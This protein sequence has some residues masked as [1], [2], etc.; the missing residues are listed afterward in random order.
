MLDTF[1]FPGGTTTAES[2][3]MG[4]PVLTLAGKTFLSRQG[5]G[6]LMNVGLT[7][8]IA[9]DADD[10]VARAVS[11]AGDLLAL[12]ALRGTLRQQVLDSPLFDARRFAGHFEAALRGMWQAWCD[13]RAGDSTQQTEVPPMNTFLHVGCGGSYKDRTTRG[14]N[15]SEWQELRLDIDPN[16]NP[17]IVGTMLDMSAVADSSADALFSSHNIEHLYAHEVPLALAEFRRVLKPDGFVV[18][19]CPDL[20]SVCQLVAEDKLTEPAY[21]SPAGP[22]AP[23]DI[24]YGLRSAL[25]RGNHYMAHRCGFTESVLVSVLHEAGFCSVVSGS[26]GQPHYDLWALASKEERAEEDMAAL[27]EAHFPE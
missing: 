1:P 7:D 2:L 4:V 18:I 14:F 22:I 24:L 25:Q 10:Y 15:T 23:L 27:V 8:W 20:Q 19:T 16:A 21:I 12:A 11:H 5:V 26:R 6:M 13:G 17:D 9:S 3:W